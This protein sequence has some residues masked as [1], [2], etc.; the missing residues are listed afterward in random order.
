MVSVAMVTYGHEQFVEQSVESVMAQKTSFPFELVIGEDCSPDRTREVVLRLQKKYAERIRLL[1]PEKNLGMMSNFIQTL[2]A[3][4]GQYI[5]IL[6][7]DD[8]WTDPCKLQKQVDLLAAHPEYSAC[9]ALTRVIGNADTVKEFFIPAR[10]T[11]KG[12]F[13]TE[14]L[15]QKNSIATA[16]VMYRNVIPQIHFA[17]L[18]SLKMID[19]PL[20]VLVSLEGPIGYL[21]E[22][23]ACYRQHA[24]GIWTGRDEA[25]RLAETVRFYSTLKQVM[26]ARFNRLI[27]ERIVKTHQL[28]ALDL[29]KRGERIQAH[30]RV[31]QSLG[32]I[33]LVHLFSFR[34]FVQRSMM[35]LRGVYGMP[36]ARVEAALSR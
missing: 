22:E 17:P 15:L 8:Y 33:P 20:H 7:G 28:I 19:W 32:A 25:A 5:A 3:C 6:E 21:P 23:M 11:A 27:S 2:Q 26:P 36:L 10:H 35:L 31:L 14:E 1:L 4:S 12:A 34:G 13:T 30:N 18:Q 16:S 24:G 9:F 29:L